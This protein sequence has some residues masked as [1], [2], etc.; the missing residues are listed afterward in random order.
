MII[1]QFNMSK[2]L[3]NNLNSKPSLILNSLKR[4]SK[5]VETKRATIRK[6]A[7][8]LATEEVTKIKT[9]IEITITEDREKIMAITITTK[10]AIMTT[11]ID[12]GTKEPESNRREPEKKLNK[13]MSF[14]KVKIG[15][16][17][18]TS[19]VTIEVAKMAEEVTEEEVTIEVTS[20]EVLEEGTEKDTVT[21]ITE[22]SNF[23]LI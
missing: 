2:V 20:E 12:K 14:M 16:K 13:G 23:P 18:Q 10:D 8:R 22:I 15:K 5:Q 21:L 6:E 7:I 9:M 11:G 4:K 19:E 1:K 3:M 17:L